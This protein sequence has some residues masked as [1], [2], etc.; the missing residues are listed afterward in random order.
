MKPSQEHYD[1]AKALSAALEPLIDVCLA[2]GITSPEIE[3]LLRVAF[4]Q[5]AFAKLP[6]HVN[7][8][9]GPSD[10][11]V[12]LAA[13]VH[14]SEVSKIRAAG[15]TTSAKGKMEIKERLYSKSARVLTGWTTDPR[16]MTSGGQP[17]DVPME[18]NKQRKSFEDLVDKYAPGNHPGS[19]LKELRRRG[20][21]ELVEP[22]IIRFKTLATRSSGATETNV[23][24][25]AKRMKR[26]GETLF[27]NILDAQQSRLYAETKTIR[28]TAEE[29]ALVRPVLERRA[30]T[31]IEALESEFR[32]RTSTSR[33]ENAKKIGVSV[34][35]WDED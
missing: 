31:F 14:R 32:A 18:R 28:L 13:G 27:Q 17:L 19:V 2:I 16:F 20:N 9:R 5:R 30:K 10:T 7:T 4:V 34:F 12:S 24:H 35:S 29:I 15:G 6:R 25:A 26:L 3:S 11:R 21:V 8:G 23:A 33:H 1:V 22:D